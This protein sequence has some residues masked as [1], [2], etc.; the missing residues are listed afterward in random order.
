M[1]II[2]LPYRG[3]GKPHALTVVTNN[4][5][6]PSFIE[7]NTTPFTLRE[8]KEQHIVP[9][10]RDAVPAISH[11]EFIETAQDVIAY[12]FSS[13]KIA[14]PQI[15]LSHMIRGRHPEALYKPVNE[16]QEWDTTTYY[17]RAGFIITIDS[18]AEEIAG[19]RL[20]LSVAGVR[21][22]DQ[23][24][25][26]AKSNADQHFKVAIGWSVRVCCNQTIAVN[27]Y[28]GDI[29]V[30][31]VDQLKA[32][33]FQLI[34]SFDAITQL[35]RLETLPNYYLS[36][37][38]FA[39][40]VGKSKMYGCLPATSKRNIPE[41]LFNDSQINSIVRSYYRDENFC[42]QNGQISLFNLLN[43]MTGANKSSYLDGFIQKSVNASVIVEHLADALEGRTNSWFLN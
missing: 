27:G 12:Q 28:S 6:K 15:R 40:F 13:E 10:F 1:E 32:A 35:K 16:L 17:A 34:G 3:N 41:L 4:N 8:I 33:I 26:S 21:A 37:A 11:A 23:D 20:S 24:S 43:N 31:N 18:I 36:E 7:S 22:H 19:Q 5:S 2:Q 39:H 14:E 9:V 30:K 25:L 42:Q 29:A 38:Q